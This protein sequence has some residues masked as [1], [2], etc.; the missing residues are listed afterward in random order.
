MQSHRC[1]DSCRFS[2]AKVFAYYIIECIGVLYSVT[3]PTF[4]IFMT[5]LNDVLKV[6]KE[7]DEAIETSKKEVEVLV[8]N[9]RE[10]QR[11][12]LE[13]ERLKLQE[14]GEAETKRQQAHVDELV[15]KIVVDTETQVEG[16]EKRFSNKKESVKTAL[17]KHFQ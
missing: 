12:R 14:S 15:K 13:A 17:M 9:A 4:Y 2:H 1:I 5:A 3:L 7:A 11:S 8:V 6:E 16:I 10:E